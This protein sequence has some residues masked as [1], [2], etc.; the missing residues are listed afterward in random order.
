MDQSY[1][2]CPK[3]G[4]QNPKEADECLRCGLVFSKYKPLSITIE[5]EK[6]KKSYFLVSIL[7]IVLISFLS[8]IIVIVLIEKKFFKE[9]EQKLGIYNLVI[10]LEI[11]YKKLPI[12]DFKQKEKYLKEI[13]TIEKILS[14]FPVSEDME[15]IDIFLQN[16]NDIKEILL[17]NK[18]INDGLKL[19]IEER[20]KKLK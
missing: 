9:K 20:F 16:L 5:K 12:I 4:T 19:K 10:D 8:Y 17:G 14:T 3:C 18:E 15:K 11:I 1:R 6:I 7:T 2:Y 13:N